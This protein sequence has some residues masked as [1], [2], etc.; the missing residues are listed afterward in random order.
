MA[1]L[2][3]S[4][5]SDP[6]HEQAKTSGTTASKVCGGALD[7]SAG[8]S[9]QNLAGTDRFDESTG[10]DETGQ[11]RSFS[12]QDAVR[13]LHDEYRQRP[14]CWV[15]KAGDES[16]KPLLE[17]RF[18][19][20]QSYPAPSD[21]EVNGSKVR[22]PVG[23]YAQVGRDGADL[24]FQCPTR[25]GSKD[26]Y[27]GDTKYVKAELYSTRSQL[28]G[29]S[30]DKDRMVILNSV[31]REVAQEAGCASEADLPTGVPDA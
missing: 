24:F 12:V 10:A 28:R 6:E 4:C 2:V 26:A 14:A 3:A 19:A 20:S 25:A 11:P 23:L 27:I 8:Q 13:H 16:G 15:Y 31:S 1:L 22:Y 30:I 5:S 17:I 21:K 9:L 18:S 29:D 7:A